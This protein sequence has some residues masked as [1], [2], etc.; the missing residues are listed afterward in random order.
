[1]TIQSR[2]GAAM[3]FAIETAMRAG[4]ICNAKWSDLNIES[5]LLH[6]PLTKNGHPRTV[7]LSN[8]AVKIIEHLAQ[9]KTE[10]TDTYSNLKAAHLTQILE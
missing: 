8:T 9:I 2:V 3:L 7:P 6:I 10:E 5:R 4:E 1:M